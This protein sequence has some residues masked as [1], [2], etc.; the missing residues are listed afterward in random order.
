ME[1]QLGVPILGGGHLKGESTSIKE[2]G[3]QRELRT[4]FHS[5][6]GGPTEE[7]ATRN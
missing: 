1:S 3:K 7:E 6:R 4:I 2:R 5:W